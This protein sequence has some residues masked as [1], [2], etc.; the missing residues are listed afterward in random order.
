MKDLKKFTK[1][2]NIFII[3]LYFITLPVWQHTVFFF[4]WPLKCPSH[5]TAYSTVRYLCSIWQRGVASSQRVVL[6]IIVITV[7][8]RIHICVCFNFF[9]S[10]DRPF[11]SAE[12][13]N[14]PR[15]LKKSNWFKPE[16]SFTFTV[17]IQYIY[18]NQRQTCLFET[19]NLRFRSLLG[20]SFRIQLIFSDLLGTVPTFLILAL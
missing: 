16:S 4:N 6:S 9:A 11:S 13:V 15:V 7:V 17:I 19:N 1:K 12:P 8:L 14:F 5:Y 20:K 3:F 10:S 18:E 2:F